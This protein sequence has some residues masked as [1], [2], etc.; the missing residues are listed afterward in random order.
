M[1]HRFLVHNLNHTTLLV[2]ITAVGLPA[3]IYPPE[4]VPQPVAARRFQNWPD[5]EQ[6]LL[7]MGADPEHLS[8]TLEGIKKNGTAVITIV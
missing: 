3:E 1:K 4:G 5:A 8:R 6:Y 7:G 2:D